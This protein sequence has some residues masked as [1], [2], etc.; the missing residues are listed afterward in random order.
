MYGG[1]WGGFLSLSEQSAFCT[2]VKFSKVLSRI[3]KWVH[4]HSFTQAHNQNQTTGDL[5]QYI[6]PQPVPASIHSKYH[7]NWQ[8]K[9]TK[10]TRVHRENG[11]A[12]ISL[13]LMTQTDSHPPSLTVANRDWE[14]W[15]TQHIHTENTQT[16]VVV[17]TCQQPKIIMTAFHV[18]QK[19]PLYSFAS[20]NVIYPLSYIQQCSFL[21]SLSSLYPSFSPLTSYL[22]IL[23]NTL[24]SL[25]HLDTI[26][27]LLLFS[28]HV[29][30]N[31]ER[32]RE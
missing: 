24:P 3:S 19:N 6:L 30:P 5:F 1:G 27:A 12:S 32:G 4:K 25:F 15:H 10:C 23:Y 16:W 26:S 20:Y 22:D 11:C 7:Y 17:L 8:I 14:Q 13:V 2:I 31:R 28:I 9:S 18:W 29:W 21:L